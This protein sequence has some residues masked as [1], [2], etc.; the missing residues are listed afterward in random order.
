MRWN[1]STLLWIAVLAVVIPLGVTRIRAA[2]Q[3][4][5]ERIEATVATL[6]SSLEDREPRRV[7]R[8]LTEDFVDESTGYGRRD[9]VD[10]SKVTLRPTGERYRAT[11]DETDGFELL[12]LVDEPIKAATV[13]IHALIEVGSV[14]GNFRPF[15]DLEAT[16]DLERRGGR[17]R[18]VRSRDV[19]HDRRPRW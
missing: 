13:R 18:V 1:R 19:S 17:W 14:N 16:L 7:A 9:V 6:L 4:S 12:S 10:A 15:W 5:E 3:S 2:L 11:L 8:I